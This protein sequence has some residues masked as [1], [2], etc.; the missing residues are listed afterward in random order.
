VLEITLAGPG[1]LT[2]GGFE[3]TREAPFV[4]PIVLMAVGA[5][6]ALF[7][8]LRSIAHL[9]AVRAGLLRRPTDPDDG[10]T[11]TSAHKLATGQTARLRVR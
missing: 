9:F 10:S 4:W 1:E 5:L 3:I 11:A 2:L 7:F 6:I 8:G